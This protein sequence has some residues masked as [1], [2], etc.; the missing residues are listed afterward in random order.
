MRG[1]QRGEQESLHARSR[2]L[3]Q[4][5]PAGRRDLRLLGSRGAGRCGPSGICSR[6]TVLEPEPTLPQLEPQPGPF[7]TRQGVHGERSTR[8]QAADLFRV[9][10]KPFLRT[11]IDS[12]ISPRAHTPGG[13]ARTWIPG[14]WR[15]RHL[16]SRGPEARAQ[17]AWLPVQFGPLRIRSR[18]E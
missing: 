2:V 9:E 7:A 3:F 12:L 10:T 11:S 16:R 13:R 18:D 5:N 8:M 15:L 17:E 1:P 14:D 4:R 6:P